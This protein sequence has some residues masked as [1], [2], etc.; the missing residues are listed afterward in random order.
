MSNRRSKAPANFITENHIK[1]AKLYLAF[2]VLP[3]VEWKM[4]QN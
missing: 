3:K 1:E 4:F 2:Y